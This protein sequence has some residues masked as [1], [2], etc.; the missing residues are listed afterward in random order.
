MFS[1]NSVL[2]TL[3][4]YQTNSDSIPGTE[5]FEATGKLNDLDVS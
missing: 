3:R 2:E 5:T 1:E 4:L